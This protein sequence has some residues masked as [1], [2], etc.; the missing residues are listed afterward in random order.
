MGYSSLNSSIF[1]VLFRLILLLSIASC[2][3]HNSLP[4][5]RGESIVLGVDFSQ[6]PKILNSGFQFYNEDSVAQHPLDILKEAGISTIR[7]K[8]WNTLSG[9]ASLDECKSYVQEINARD[10]DV[11]L[12]MHYSETWADPGAQKIPQKWEHLSFEL[13]LDSVEFFTHKVVTEL[14]P[15]FIQIG[16]EINHGFLYPHGKRDGTGR[17]QKL[18]QQGIHGAKSSDSS[19]VTMIHFAGISGAHA[20]FSSVD[21]VAYDAIGLSFYP[22]W[23]TKDIGAFEK[24]CWELQDK[25]Q[26]PVYIVETSYPF[27]LDW[28]DFTNNHIGSLDQIIPEFPPTPKGQKD[29]VS[30]LK[31]IADSLGTGLLYWGAE[32]V[33][34]DG[35]E[36]QQGSVYE[37]QALFDFNGQALPALRELGSS[38]Q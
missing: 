1:S 38:T 6:L 4:D 22:R 14:H 28:A 26:R 17:F 23:H 8:V 30:E 15:K 31:H 29:F 19:V 11:M 32:L 36:S 21:S 25:F 27:T 3:K 13:L 33:A 12:T 7:L 16:N 34:F 2:S 9:T 20:F 24:V 18:L 37:N 35:P 10:L 5:P